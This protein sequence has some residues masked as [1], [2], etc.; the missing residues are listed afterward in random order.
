VKIELTNKEGWDN[1]SE[2]EKEDYIVKKINEKTK[3]FSLSDRK[4]VVSFIKEQLKE[5]IDDDIEGDPSKLE[6]KEAFSVLKT[7]EIL[8]DDAI[9]K[10]QESKD[11]NKEDISEGVKIIEKHINSDN[12]F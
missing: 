8:V 11:I 9:S 12:F 4:K 10:K 6:K 7:V 2:E 5:A 3:D 1:F